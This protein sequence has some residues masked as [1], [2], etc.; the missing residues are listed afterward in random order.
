VYST[1]TL[2]GSRTPYSESP[3]SAEVAVRFDTPVGV[4]NASL[5]YW[6]DIFL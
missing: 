6:L 1:A 3:L 5:A 4:F 2:G